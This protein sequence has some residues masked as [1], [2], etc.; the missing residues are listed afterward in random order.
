MPSPLVNWGNFPSCEASI[1]DDLPTM[2]I[3]R[4]GTIAHITAGFSWVSGQ[5]QMR[6]IPWAGTIL[7]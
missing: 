4:D 6:H 2:V 5:S 7:P 1:L 3:K